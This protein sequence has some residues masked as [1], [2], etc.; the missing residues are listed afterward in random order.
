[1]QNKENIALR[2]LDLPTHSVRELRDEVE[3]LRERMKRNLKE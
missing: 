3:A 2:K 1:M